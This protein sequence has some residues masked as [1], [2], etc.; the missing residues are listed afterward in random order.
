[1]AIDSERT[2]TYLDMRDYS[3]ATIHSSYEVK[4][5]EAQRFLETLDEKVKNFMPEDIETGINR[6]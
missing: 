2:L 3:L 5:M 6:K 4:E 1:M